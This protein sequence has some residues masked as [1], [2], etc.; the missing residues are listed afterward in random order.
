MNGIAIASSSTIITAQTLE[1]SGMVFSGLSPDGR[2]VEIAELVR[3]S[4]HG[5]QP[6]PS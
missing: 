5:R 6:V 3:S 4:V 2:L 1:A